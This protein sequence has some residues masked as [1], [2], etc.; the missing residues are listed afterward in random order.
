MSAFP[1]SCSHKLMTIMVHVSH[2]FYPT[3]C[4]L[5]HKCISVQSASASES[6]HISASFPAIYTKTA[7]LSSVSVPACCSSIPCGAKINHAFYFLSNS[8]QTTFYVDIFWYTDTWMNFPS[9][10]YF[11]LF[12]DSSTENLNLKLNILFVCM[13]ADDNINSSCLTVKK[14]GFYYITCMYWKAIVIKIN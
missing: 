14:I 12:I 13:V 2:E 5:L 10:A 1:H 8:C 4:N 6:L 3:L 9:P 7:S 11:T